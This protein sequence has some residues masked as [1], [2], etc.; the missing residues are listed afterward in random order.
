MDRAATPESSPSPPPTPLRLAWPHSTQLATAFLLGAALTLL[1]IQ[2]WQSLAGGARPSDLQRTRSTLLDLNRAGR[3]ELMQLPGIGPAL[4]ERIETHRQTHG[5]FKSVDDLRA[6][7]GIG[8]VTLDRIRPWV[9][10]SQSDDEESMPPARLAMDRPA[11]K[12]ETPLASLID[13]NLASAEELQR[14][15]GIGPVLS[16]RIMEQRPFQ[17]VDELRRVPGIGPKT[18]EKLRPLV[19][20]RNEVGLSLAE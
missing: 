17:K 2:V 9:E 7:H 14:L 16:K 3:A 20:V 11:S 6:V 18:M 15:P 1:A 13:L 4:A 10:V 5:H 19:C 8:P 12:K